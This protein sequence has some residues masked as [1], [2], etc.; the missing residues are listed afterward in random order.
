MSKDAISMELQ[1]QRVFD[2]L[3]DWRMSI[4]IKTENRLMREYARTKAEL[5]DAPE[6]QR[7]I[8][9]Y[10]TIL[11]NINSWHRQGN[12]SDESYEA[13][14]LCRERMMSRIRKIRKEIDRRKEPWWTVVKKAFR[15]VS[16]TLLHALPT[17]KKL[18]GYL[19][20]GTSVKDM[21]KLPAPDKDQDKDDE[22]GEDK[23]HKD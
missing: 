17:L 22:E 9:I 4:E 3:D 7:A 1:F 15:E 23:D 5:Q 8:K 16:E 10:K 2:A 12:L 14:R 6:Y 11:S 21:L 13:Y 19:E 18:I 20:L